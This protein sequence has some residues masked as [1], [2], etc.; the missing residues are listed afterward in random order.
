MSRSPFA[1]SPVLFSPLSSSFSSM[2]LRAFDF[3]MLELPLFSEVFLS[4]SV[5]SPAFCMLSPVLSPL[6]FRRAVFSFSPNFRRASP[7]VT[8]AHKIRSYRFSDAAVFFAS[9]S[10]SLQL[11]GIDGI[12]ARLRRHATSRHALSSV[13]SDAALFIFLRPPFYDIA[14]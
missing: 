2:P 11:S 9:F 14:R 8:L 10:P 5:F 1:A 13:F 12:A 7:Y 4:F 3:V 6:R